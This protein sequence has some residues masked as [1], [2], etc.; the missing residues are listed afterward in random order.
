MTSLSVWSAR[1][2]QEQSLTNGCFR[3]MD[4]DFCNTAEAISGRLNTCSF[5]LS[6]L[7]PFCQMA[8]CRACAAQPMTET[9]H[10][11]QAR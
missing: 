8:G 6:L 2:G 3:A 9:Q 7:S 5:F 4:S 1:I 10:R 11:W